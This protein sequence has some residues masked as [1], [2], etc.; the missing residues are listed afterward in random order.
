[1]EA[2]MLGS[3]LTALGILFDPPRLV[4]L[5]LGVAIGLFVG[6]VPGIGGIV[7]LSILLPFSFDMDPYAA[8][9]MMVGVLAV[10]VT[11]DSIPAIL[12]GVPGSVGCAATVL[13]GYPLARKGEAGRAFGAAFG[14]SV[15]GGLFGALLLGLLVPV[16]R[17]IVLLVGSPELLSFCLFGLSLVAV[18]S[19]SSPL[20]GLSAA[21]MGILLA[22]VGDDPQ[23][24]TLR[25]TFDTLYLWDGLSV[26]PIALGVF[27]IPEIADLAITQSTVAKKAMITTKAAQIEGFKD[28]MKHWFLMCRCSA[29][30]AGLGTVPGM[31]SSVVDWIAYGHAARTEKGAQETFGRGDI[32]GVIASEASNNAREGGALVPTVAF[33]VPGSAS[34]ALILGAFLIHGIVPGPE[35]L[36]KNLNITYT[37]VWSIAVAN[38]FGA[39]ICFF[40]ANQLAKLALVRASILVPLIMGITYI[41]AM[42]GSKSWGD[43]YV[44]LGI[45]VLAWIMKLLK[46]PRPPMLLGFILGGLIERYMF[47]S[48]ERYGAS[49]M[50]RPVVVVMLLLTLY[51]ILSPIIR[52]FMARGSGGPRLRWSPGNISPDLV[53]TF[54][55]FLFFAYALWSS[56]G[57]EFGAR[58][59]PQVI[60]WSGVVF[61]VAMLAIGFLFKPVRGDVPADKPK[62]AFLAFDPRRQQQVDTGHLDLQTD[63]SSLTKQQFWGRTFAFF[64]WLLGYLAIAATI[65]ILPGML[66]YLIAYMH[67]QGKESLVTTLKIVVPVWIFVYVLFH[68]ILVQPWPQTLLG[69]LFPGL[70]SIFYLNLI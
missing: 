22:T 21:A 26:V 39:G 44:L 34:Q 19:G 48:V 14:A 36:T 49:W 17:P 68:L 46:W 50:W 58:L 23:T 30:G 16:L 28:V 41:G 66:V 10:N 52:S 69:D 3:A 7:A 65:G 45:G 42:E 40:F 2:D 5:V 54:L 18:L 60:A 64:A 38:I 9:A 43:L 1:M 59:V 55:V 61:T 4:F 12:F 53:F 6:I 31:S 29:I 15:L 67:I 25:W 35:M 8:L 11:S 62:E 63:Y 37:L 27:A 32:R 20:K 24:G 47:I 57:W 56:R 33:G 51:G 70:R 13:D